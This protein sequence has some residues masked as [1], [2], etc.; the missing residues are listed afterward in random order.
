MGDV[1][2]FFALARDIARTVVDRYA[3]Q[4]SEIYG[5][6]PPIERLAEF[7]MKFLVETIRD[8]DLRLSKSSRTK[9]SDVKERLLRWISLAKSNFS[10][11]ILP[12]R[13]DPFDNDLPLKSGDFW[14]SNEFF[15]S[16]AIRSPDGN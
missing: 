14:S 6:G 15:R 3:T 1:T 16:P 7:L 12:W 8:K 10:P 2:G 13:K 5:S 11:G 4:L 9:L